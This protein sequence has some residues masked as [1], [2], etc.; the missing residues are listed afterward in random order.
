MT[1]ILPLNIIHIIFIT[2]LSTIGFIYFIKYSIIIW[3]IGII[4]IIFNLHTWIVN[5]SHEYTK[6]YQ[7]YISN[8]KSFI[9]GFFIFILTEVVFFASF[10]WTYY[11]FLLD[12]NTYIGGSWPP[13]Y[14]VL[15]KDIPLHMDVLL[16]DMNIS[17]ICIISIIVIGSQYINSVLI[18]FWSTFII[19]CMG[20]FFVLEHY[21]D[22]FDIN[23]TKVDLSDGIF[24][25]NLHIIT[26]LHS[27]HALIGIYMIC[28][29]CFN[30]FR[31]RVFYKFEW[32]KINTYFFVKDDIF[33]ISSFYYWHLI[34]LIWILVFI[35]QY[36]HYTQLDTVIFNNI[37]IIDNILLING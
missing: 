11:N 8:K 5:L 30:T 1:T 36:T 7:L 14:N 23:G 10:F 13:M 33:T 24:S 20:F 35:T 29:I 37:C 2:I 15:C 3:I 4:L 27:I 12:P 16:S 34:D 6:N 18:E 22:L 9:K 25:S 21:K 32:S 31:S 26:G 17:L 28:M 19:F